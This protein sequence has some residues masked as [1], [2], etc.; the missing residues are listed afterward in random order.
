M[1]GET[2]YFTISPVADTSVGMVSSTDN[3]N[4]YWSYGYPIGNIGNSAKWKIKKVNDA[5]S[6]LV[7]YPTVRYVI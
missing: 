4:K 7:L 1:A 5:Y 3:K 2:D 6:E